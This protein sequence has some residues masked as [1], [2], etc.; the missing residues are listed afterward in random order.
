[1]SRFFAALKD[2]FK[3][4][5]NVNYCNTPTLL[6]SSYSQNNTHPQKKF[7]VSFFPAHCL[8]LTSVLAIYFTLQTSHFPLYLS[9]HTLV[10]RLSAPCLATAAW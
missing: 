8:L 4:L 7:Q 10:S 1:M 3:S 6:L 2:I 9:H 5:R